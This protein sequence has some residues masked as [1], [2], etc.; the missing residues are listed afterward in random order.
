MLQYIAKIGTL[1]SIKIF[2]PILSIDDLSYIF[3][4]QGLCSKIGLYV[5]ISK[6]KH[7]LCFLTIGA[8]GKILQIHQACKRNWICEKS[9]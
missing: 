2:N 8:K 7:E 5:K 1:L 3:N 4:S 9:N 6:G